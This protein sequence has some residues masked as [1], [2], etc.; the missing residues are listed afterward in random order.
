MARPRKA[1]TGLRKGILRSVW[2]RIARDQMGA[3]VIMTLVLLMAF[4][5]YI[6]VY[7]KMTKNG[8]YRSHL[9]SQL[10]EARVD[11][12]RLRA[13]IQS[14]SS[15]D[16]LAKIATDSGMQVCDQFD[17]LQDNPAVVV[18]DAGRGQGNQ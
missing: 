12:L 6:G 14:L 8:Y 2:R 7:A 17:Y 18:A 16:R 10:R 15:P 9:L 13:D 3:A 4:L 11:N 5:C 1:K